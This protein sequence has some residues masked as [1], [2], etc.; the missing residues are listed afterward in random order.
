MR[1]GPQL[2]LLQSRAGATGPRNTTKPILLVGFQHQGNLG[3]GYLASTLR[4]HGYSVVICDFEAEPELI[5]NTSRW[6][7]TSQA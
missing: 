4:E 6:A 7:D 1:D 5:V 2:T 3:L